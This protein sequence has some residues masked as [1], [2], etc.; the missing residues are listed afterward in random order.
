MGLALTRTQNSRV[1]FCTEAYG[2]VGRYALAPLTSPE[3]AINLISTGLGLVLQPG[4]V[5]LGFYQAGSLRVRVP[6]GLFPVEGCRPTRCPVE[7]S[8]LPVG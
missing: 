7:L 6:G 1:G 8:D 2:A 3:H 4:S 5:G